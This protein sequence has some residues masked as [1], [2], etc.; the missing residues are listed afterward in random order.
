M[1]SSALAQWLFQ[2]QNVRTSCFCLD[3]QWNI[4]FLQNIVCGDL[5]LGSRVIQVLYCRRGF[6]DLVLVLR[7]V[8]LPAG[9]QAH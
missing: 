2:L 5:L 9:G 7:R 3:K 4:T 1:F 6:A 8:N